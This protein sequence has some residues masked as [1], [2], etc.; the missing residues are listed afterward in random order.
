MSTIVWV[1]II[2]VVLL[3]L[4]LFFLYVLKHTMSDFMKPTSEIDSINHIKRFL[5]YNFEDNYETIEHSS[6]NNHPDRPLKVILKLNDVTID[7][8]QRFTTLI[9]PYS[10]ETISDDKKTKYVEEVKKSLLY[11]EKN[12]K[13]IHINSESSEYVFFIAKLKIDYNEKILLYHETGI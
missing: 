1:V 3:A 12:H 13:A 8:I 2:V 9:E 6:Q 4:L 10:N 7:K 11:F 5:G